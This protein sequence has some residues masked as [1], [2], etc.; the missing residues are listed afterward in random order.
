MQIEVYR[1]GDWQRVSND[2]PRNAWDEDIH[3]LRVSYQIDGN[4]YQSVI[5]LKGVF[6]AS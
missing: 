2:L 3:G 6:Y 4:T 5:A 1:D